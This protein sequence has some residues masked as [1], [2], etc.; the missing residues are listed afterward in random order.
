MKKYIFSLVLISLI[1]ISGYSQNID[2]LMKKVSNTESIEKVKINGF[3][4][5]LAKTFGGTKDMPVARGVKSM[6]IFTLSNNDSHL[7]DDF[8]KLFNNTKDEK[9]YETL[10][11]VKD[12]EE[13]IRIMVKKDKDIINNMIFLCMDKDEPTI[14]RFSGKIKEKDIQELVDKYNK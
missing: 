3:M 12:K 8:I 4:M 10:I 14:I 7:K 6:E 9:G 13:G 5:S 1:S 11:F 2:Q